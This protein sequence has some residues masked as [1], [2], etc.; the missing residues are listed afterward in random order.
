M[1]LLSVA[2]LLVLAACSDAPEGEDKLLA[3]VHQ[4]ELR[5]SELAGMF[6][7]NAT[8]EDSSLVIQAF[9]TRWCKET[10]LQ[11]EAER[12]LPA[13]LNIDRLVRDYRASLVS[14]HYEEV[15]V[16]MRLDSTI[17][18]EQLTAYYEENKS[19]YLLERPIV[20][21]FLIRV[22]HPVQD[23]EELQSLW[24]NG[25]ISD[26]MA[27]K[28]YCERFAEVSL[29]QPASWYSLDDIASQLPK[30]VLTAGNIN[31]KREFSLQEG[32]FRYYFRLLEVKP[33]L[34]IAP[35]S[36]VE[37]QA[38][39]VILHNRK[40]EVLEQAR[41]EIFDRELRRNNIETFTNE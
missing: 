18:P 1:A 14:T 19:Q 36:Y 38:R 28:N 8:A 29:L 7:D 11:W 10:A 41:E 30:G 4:K 32:S 9:V 16:A 3:R 26:T 34:E 33:R 40:R 24:N 5:L 2:G 20:R 15:L 37:D 6:P 31:S 21:C 17:S 25:E 35:L 27:L 39:N 22:P 13:D 12:N 23:A